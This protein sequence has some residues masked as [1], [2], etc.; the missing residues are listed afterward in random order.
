MSDNWEQV[1][2]Y[3]QGIF[4]HQSTWVR[5]SWVEVPQQSSIPLLEWLARLLC[6]CALRIDMIRDD[7]FNHALRAAVWV[8]R[9][10]WA[11]LGDGNHVGDTGGIA[12]DGRG[13]GEDDVGDIVFGHAAEEG[14]SAAHI[15]AVVFERDL[16]GFANRLGIL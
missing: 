5:T 16:G 15:D 12:I 3:A 4:A 13:G 8:G 6:V 2:G 10:D 14:D 11:V 9:T 7:I 1:E